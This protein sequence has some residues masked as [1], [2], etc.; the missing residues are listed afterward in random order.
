MAGP[1]VQ[2]VVV[3]GNGGIW[4]G[5][6]NEV[7][8]AAGAAPAAAWQEVGFATDDG[9]VITSDHTVTPVNAWQA[10]GAIRNLTTDAPMSVKFTCI[11]F[12]PHVVE[13]AF[14]GGSVDGTTSTYTPGDPSDPAIRAVLIR[15]IDGDAVIDAWFP[16]TQL[17][18]S[19]DINLQKILETRVP[20]E[21]GVLFTTPRFLINTLNLPS[22]VGV[23]PLSVGAQSAAPKAGSKAA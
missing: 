13:L 8:P 9:A 15:G 19:R 14:S 11:E 6:E 7:A 4:V 17:Q 23:G 2:N 22:W 12:T 3:A 20:I 10:L 21:L 16:R 5:P 1:D 18:A